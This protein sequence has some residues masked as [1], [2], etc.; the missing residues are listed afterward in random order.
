MPTSV[1]YKLS[2][3]ITEIDARGNADLQCL[4]V[5]K[6]WLERPGRLARP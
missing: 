1:T 2:A 5:L 4:T 6:R 3:V